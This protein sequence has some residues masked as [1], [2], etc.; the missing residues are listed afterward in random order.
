MNPT[1]WRR[2]E[3]NRA[4]HALRASSLRL[5]VV[6]SI[7]G[8]GMASCTQPSPSAEA[9]SSAGL[10]RFWSSAD[11]SIHDAQRSLRSARQASGQL[12]G[13]AAKGDYDSIIAL[14][15]RLGGLGHDHATPKDNAPVITLL[16]TMIASIDALTHVAATSAELA[17]AKGATDANVSKLSLRTQ[18]LYHLLTA[19]KLVSAVR[20]RATAVGFRLAR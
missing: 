2:S 16:D 13:E 19:K 3:S 11:E 5:A 20:N 7:L 14:G 17:E 1:K 8:I 15:H 6:L 10:N 9:R 12:G 18:R 4:F